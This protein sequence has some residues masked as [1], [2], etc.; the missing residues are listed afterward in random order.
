MR[1]GVRILVAVV[2][3]V[4]AGVLLG[5]FALPAGLLGGWAV[6]GA[7]FVAW[8]W[9]VI[10]PMDAAETKAHAIRE[11]PERTVTHWI[12]VLAAIASLGAVV[13][14]LL[15]AGGRKNLLTMSAV[16]LSVFVSWA[17]VH[18]LYSLN[19]ARMYYAQPEGGVDFHQHE[20]PCYTD[21]TYMGVTVGMSFAISDTDLSASSFRRV[22]Q[23]HA[24]LSYLF[25][26]VIVAL[27]VNLVAGLVGG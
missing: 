25:G 13:V 10:V 24:L 26:T 16:L 17:V 22:A 9:I 20:P 23:V 8:T 14:V 15:G 21:F 6:A 18:T 12:L 2:I 7:V 4:V 11:Q 3:G 1:P 5:W 19:Y 27:L